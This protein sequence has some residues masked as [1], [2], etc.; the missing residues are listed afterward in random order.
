VAPP[1][2]TGVSEEPPLP[3]MPPESGARTDATGAAASVP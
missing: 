3:P 2:E 1:P